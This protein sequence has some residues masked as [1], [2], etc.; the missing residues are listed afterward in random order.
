MGLWHWQVLRAKPYKAFSKK[1]SSLEPKSK[2]KKK[3]KLTNGLR[4]TKKIIFTVLR[5]CS[6]K[7][8]EMRRK[9]IATFQAVSVEPRMA[10][11]NKKL[12][13]NPKTILT[14]VVFHN[15]KGYDAHHLMQAM[16]KTDG[17]RDL[18]CLAKNME[19]IFHSLWETCVLSTAMHCFQASTHL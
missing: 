5:Y 14:P 6:A 18:N 7:I 8:S 13:I 11:C 4:K 10:K 17:A 2:E 19:N 15:L 12:R 3:M 16:S 9:I 1:T